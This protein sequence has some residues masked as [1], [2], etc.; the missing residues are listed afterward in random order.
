MRYQLTRHKFDS[1]SPQIHRISVVIPSHARSPRSCPVATCRRGFRRMGSM[2][3]AKAWRQRMTHE[4]CTWHVPARHRMDVRF[5]L[6][7][8]LEICAFCRGRNTRC[9]AAH[10]CSAA[11]IPQQH[12]D[13]A[14]HLIIVVVAET[15]RRYQLPGLALLPGRV[16]GE[17]Q[18]SRGVLRWQRRKDDHPVCSGESAGMSVVADNLPAA[19]HGPYCLRSRSHPRP[20]VVLGCIDAGCATATDE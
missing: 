20:Q 5:L 10:A 12:R 8:H 6:L 9:R 15:F 1:S 19:M 2:R 17:K 4:S 18:R 7:L 14:G 16:Q 11:T 13:A 3:L